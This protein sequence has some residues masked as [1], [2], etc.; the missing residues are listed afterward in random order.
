[1]VLKTTFIFAIHFHQPIGQVKWVLDRVQKNSYEMLIDILEK[2]KDLPLTLHFSGPLLLQ[3][4]EYYPEFLERLREVLKRSR[5]EVMGGTYSESILAIIPWED[6]V[7][8]LVR[9]RKL[10]EEI[11]GI[12][13]H[14]A[15]LPERVWDPTLPIALEEAGYEYVL[16]DDTVGYHG[17]LQEKD[18]RRAWITEYSGR[19]TKVL[20][21]D[22][23]IR[24]LLPW[25]SHEEVLEYLRK[26]KSTNGEDYVL[27]GSDAEKFGE[28][29]DKDKAEQWLRVFLDKIRS[30]DWLVIDTPLNYL[31]KHGTIGLA[32]L[33]PGSYDKMME[34]SGGYFPIFIRKYVE[35]NNMHKK[36][37]YV[38][39]KLILRKA[40]AKAWEEY[41]KAQCNDPYWHGLFG[42]VYIPI[43]RQAIYEHLIRAERIADEGVLGD[44]EVFIKE[45]DFDYDDKMEL[46]MESRTLNAYIKPS[47][48]GTLFELDVKIEGYEHNLLNTMTRVMEPYL[49]GTEFIPDWYRRVS[50][51]E[52]V[53]RD[54]V[55]IHSWLR[56]E[57]FIDTSDLALA[58]YSYTITG[59]SDSIRLTYI[60]KDWKIYKKPRRIMVEKTYTLKPLDKELV[61][62][63]K[64]KNL[65]DSE[66]HAILSE[67]LTLAPRLSKDL[68]VMPKYIVDNEYVK[69][70]IEPYESQESQKIILESIDYPVVVIEQNRKSSLWVSPINSY[71]R[72]EKGLKS[73]YQALGIIFNHTVT[74]KPREEFDITITIRI[75]G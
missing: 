33:P 65:E 60:G 73:I 43:L 71:S 10:V 1:M 49:E 52:H 5:F 36:M 12:K 63:I 47:D 30:I 45:I 56:N 70:V 31:E 61:V 48:G 46:L 58:E 20:F 25:R 42:G 62:T 28:W 44:T 22:T 41:Y 16:I 34:W 14:G 29:W 38:R 13:P 51:R 7:E 75:E 18:V 26:Y 35:S 64:W 15:W 39:R 21:I 8:Q 11:L 59:N 57:P 27:W 19:K 6:R 17:G 74:L 23:T 2:H 37:L 55:D 72:T 50:F 54:G 69:Q 4:E 67:E 40:S 9:G 3:W 66:Y 53:W 32:Y 24:Y 68:P